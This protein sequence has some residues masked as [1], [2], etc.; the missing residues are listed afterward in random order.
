MLGRI[1][2]DRGDTLVEVLLAV[3][4]FSLVATGALLIMNQS[5]NAAQRSVEIT[6]VRQQIDAQA[7]ALRAVHEAASKA[8]D[9]TVGTQWAGIT[10][11]TTASYQ[12]ATCPARRSQLPA[13]TFVLDPVRAEKLSGDWYGKAGSGAVGQPP[14]AQVSP[15]KSY[16]MWIESQAN[17]LS[18]NAPGAYT[19]RIRACWDGVGLSIPQQIETVVR[20]YEL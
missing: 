17:N 7:E 12:E 6:L 13:G 5:V 20:L 14:Y 3:T 15:Q 1:Y 10:S 11:A 4:V 18:D 19:F 8:T 16:G 9:P 2:S